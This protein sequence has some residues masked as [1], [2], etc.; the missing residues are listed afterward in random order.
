MN[1]LGWTQA[2]LARAMGVKPQRV[3]DILNR[4]RDLKQ[5]TIEALALALKCDL[6]LEPKE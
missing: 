3:W 2:D 1:E 6:V 4:D 5:T